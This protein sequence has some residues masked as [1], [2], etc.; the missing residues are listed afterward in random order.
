MS[1]LATWMIIR[2][3]YWSAME[4]WINMWR[5]NE[6]P[7]KSSGSLPTLETMDGFKNRKN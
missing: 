1:Q 3:M 2:D 7:S 6:L 5:I 4:T